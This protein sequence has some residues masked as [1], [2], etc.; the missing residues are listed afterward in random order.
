M[1]GKYH[2]YFNFICNLINTNSF[3]LNMRC[4]G[5]PHLEQV[6]HMTWADNETWQSVFNVH[7]FIIKLIEH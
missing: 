2:V 1:I 7:S 6:T 3:S 4:K 5:H